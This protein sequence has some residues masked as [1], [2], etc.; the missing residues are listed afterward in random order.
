M[1]GGKFII[2]KFDL[3]PNLGISATAVVRRE[4]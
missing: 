1:V 3:K 4:K 2:R